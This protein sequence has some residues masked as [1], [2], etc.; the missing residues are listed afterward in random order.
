MT[1]LSGWENFFIIIGS[2]AAVLIGLQFVVISLIAIKPIKRKEAES[3]QSFSTPIVFYF[4]SV[5]VF[6]AIGSAPWSQISYAAILWTLLGICGFV[7][8]VITARRISMQRCI[9]RCFMTGFSM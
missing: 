6:S 2:A 4:G 9:S 3:G 1:L 8:V 5:L 7:Y